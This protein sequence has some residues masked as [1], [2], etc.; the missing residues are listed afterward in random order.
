MSLPL[1]DYWRLL[2]RYHDAQRW[3]LALLA[4]L[5]L[6]NVGLQLI[7]PVVLRR[8]IDAVGAATPPGVLTAIAL[9]FIGVALVRQVI[10]LA[11]TY[12]AGEVGGT[13]T[14][15][16]RG[17]LVR[18]CLGLDMPF[19]L[20][21]T[22]G[23][24]V[25]R[26]DG[27]VGRL[28]GFF[29]RLALQVAAS[30]LLLL[31]ALAVLATI[32]WRL[33]LVF[34]AFVAV[35][36]VVLSRIHPLAR[37]A[38][39]AERETSAALSGYVEERLAGTEDIRSRG[40]TDHVLHRLGGHLREHIHARRRAIM[41]YQVSWGA[42]IMVFAVGRAL[43]YGL[44]GA[45]FETGVVTVGTV[46]LIVQYSW[47][48]TQPLDRLT[49]QLQDLHRATASI[50]RVQELFD[51][52]TSL[53]TTTGGAR[54]LPPGPLAVAFDGVSFGYPGSSEPVL[55]E[56]SFELAPGRVLGVLGRTG[57]GKTTATR[58]L[59]RLYDPSGGTLRLGGVDARA[60]SPTRIR[61]R[62][63]MVTQEIQLFDA[64]VRDNLTFFDRSVPDARLVDALETLGLRPWLARLPAGLDTPFG[65]EGAGLSAG[66]AQLLA[67]ARVF[68]KDPSLVI[69]DEASS[70]LDPATERLLERAVDVLLR[71]RTAIVVAHRLATVR[72]ADEILILERGLVVEHGPRLALAGDPGSRFSHLLR[73]GLET[74]LV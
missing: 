8:F 73:L 45:L 38:H 6:A 50:A 16:L 71:G 66:E 72:R 9:Q 1:R 17:D 51:Q 47:M 11:E 23:Q 67:F 14:N 52:S 35:S 18:H 30:L 64:S 59:A 37:P 4:S 57:S 33:T 24:L 15:A 20:A 56:V 21:H 7:G 32:D 12:V 29:S 34:A 55:R 63:G 5:I 41:A 60:V 2:A 62:V 13:T 61:D 25:E 48:V 28:A 70:R 22:P 43:A 3:R 40:A 65:A 10:S 27:D 74:V 36:F 19:H 58:L 53:A 44:G 49:Q 39:V 26:V 68:L 54:E 69:L 42:M 31:G 46:F